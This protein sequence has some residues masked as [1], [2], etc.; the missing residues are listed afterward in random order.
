MNWIIYM[1]LANSSLLLFYLFYK[2]LLEKETFFRLNRY[3]LI[4]AAMSAM[5]IPLIPHDWL[6]LQKSIFEKVQAQEILIMLSEVSVSPLKSST[7][8]WIT[9]A[10]SI[11]LAG[12]VFFTLRLTRRLLQLRK[13]MGKPV[14]GM[15]FSFFGFKRIDSRLDG[16]AIIDRHEEVHIRHIH[17]ADI[18]FFEIL[19][20][21]YW[22]NPVIY[23]YKKSIIQVHEFYAD[24]VASAYQGDKAA[25]AMLLLS[26]ALRIDSQVLT[27]SFFNEPLLKTRIHMLNKRKSA[28]PAVLKYALFIPLCAGTL[29][30]TSATLTKEKMPENSGDGLISY[31]TAQPL[32]LYSLQQQEPGKVYEF[33]KTHTPPEF[34]GGMKKFYEYLGA[35]IKYPESAAKNKVEGR[36]FLSYIVEKDGKISN[37]KVEKGLNAALDAEAVRVLTESPN[38]IP[39]KVDNTPVRVKFNIPINFGLTKKPV[40]A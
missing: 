10:A 5:L 7:P 19:S 12:A 4:T 40:K 17:S 2:L 23:A 29:L 3:Y 34:P 9:V 20:I 31:F 15:A 33:V 32:N 18:I 38:W 16:A 37:V 8:G 36:V 35:S 39:G 26:K 25:Y 6:S 24:E 28:K 22:F 13:T 14:S 27:N 30:L 21:I 1:L 11:Y